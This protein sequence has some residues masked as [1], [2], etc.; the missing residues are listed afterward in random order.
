M[1]SLEREN[2]PAGCIITPLSPSDCVKMIGDISSGKR[3][4]SAS[5]DESWLLAHCDDGVVWG[6]AEPDNERLHLSWEAFAGISPAIKTERLQSLRLFCHNAEILIWKAENEFRGRLLMDAPVSDESMKPLRRSVCLLG[7]RV[8]STSKGFSL[9]E[10]KNGS[11]HAPPL[12]VTFCDRPGE[13]GR[14]NILDYFS[15]D[16]ESGKIR[17]SASRLSSLEQGDD[18]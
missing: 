1:N 18:R 12:N 5:K 8:V 2:L 17:I 4:S 9:L 11:R 13:A 15:K 7:T 14:I 16:D 10:D 3:P 6:H